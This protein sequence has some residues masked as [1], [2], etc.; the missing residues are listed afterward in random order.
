MAIIRIKVNDNVLV[1]FLQFLKKF[2]SGSIEIV[3][4][5][6]SS[7][8]HNYVNEQLERLESGLGKTYNID[9]VDQ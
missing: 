9:E 2:K 3:K 7:E 1:Q 5:Q 4:E 8:V 6:E